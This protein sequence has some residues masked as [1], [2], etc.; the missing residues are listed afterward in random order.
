[1]PAEQTLETMPLADFIALP[2][3]ASFIIRFNALAKNY[4]DRHPYTNQGM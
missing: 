1:M 3:T 2:D 4:I